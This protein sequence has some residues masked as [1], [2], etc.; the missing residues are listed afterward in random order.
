[1]C[2]HLCCKHSC[3]LTG[4]HACS[5]WKSISVQSLGSSSFG[6]AVLWSSERAV[7]R[8][9]GQGAS[10]SA[11]EEGAAPGTLSASVG[12][13]RCQRQ[14]QGYHIS[15]KPEG[16]LSF[17]VGKAWQRHR[18]SQTLASSPGSHLFNWR[19]D[20]DLL[21]EAFAVI[22]LMSLSSAPLLAGTVPY[23]VMFLDRSVLK[24]VHCHLPPISG[25]CCLV[26]TAWG[27]WALSL[28]Y[29]PIKWV[30][31]FRHPM[32]PSPSSA[33]HFP[34]S[35]NL[36]DLSQPPYWDILG[37]G[38]GEKGLWR[39]CFSRGKVNSSWSTL[40]PVNSAFTVWLWH[41]TGSFWV[42]S[43]GVCPTE[44]QEAAQAKD[45]SPAQEGPR[46]LQSQAP[47][48]EQ[49]FLCSWGSGLQGSSAAAR[50]QLP[51]NSAWLEFTACLDTGIF[52]CL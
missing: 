35:G 41:P 47:Y 37:W 11:L 51:G 27:F 38:A 22:M 48:G 33:P 14:A 30:F 18:A 13:N 16:Y 8:Q 15:D 46:L 5:K 45:S 49:E 23:L 4:K 28:F 44:E 2:K 6:Q 52:S 9:E 36:K 26:L 31:F 50:E 19:W 32:A 29:C 12:P 1:M 17:S 21:P 7:L 3:R 25:L 43:V 39:E 34:E 10:H 42:W 20:R 40:C 24:P